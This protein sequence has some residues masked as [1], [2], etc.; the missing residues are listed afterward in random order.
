MINWLASYPKSGNTWMRMLLASYFDE[1][2]HELDINKLAMTNGIASARMRFDEI[3]GIDSTHLTDEEIKSLLPLVFEQI[4]QPGGAPQWIKVHD[5]QARTPTGQW[6]FPPSASGKAI[7]LIRNPLDVAVSR[8][9]HDGHEDMAVAAAMLCNPH[10]AV[11]GNGKPQLRQ[12]MGDWSHHVSSWI[13]Q[14]AIPV[15]VV[16]YEDMLDDAAR[17]LTRVIAF[18]CPDTPIDPARIAK[19]VA[20]TAFDRLQA[21]EDQ[22]GFKETTPKQKRFFRSGKAGGW[23]QHLSPEQA[24]R[25]I[26]CH[27]VMMRRF[28]YIEPSRD[29]AGHAGEAARRTC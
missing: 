3:L 21:K 27:R 1:T 5:A 9:F 29:S 8:A 19:A 20:D 6:L 14:P 10:A 4:V 13:D 28:G 24:A 15:L 12:F 22:D 17:E 25:I 7:Y 2:D 11:G 18:A 26:A 23:A 16:R